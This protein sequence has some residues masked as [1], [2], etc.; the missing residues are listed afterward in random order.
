MKKYTHI[1]TIQISDME[2]FTEE[3]ITAS[4]NLQDRGFQLEI[5]YK[6]VVQKGFFRNRIVHTC[7][8]RAYKE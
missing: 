2:K 4:E 8:I 1:K 7:M 3:V 5:D 6:P